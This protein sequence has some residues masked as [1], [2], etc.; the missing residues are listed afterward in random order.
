M[1]YKIN[2][3]FAYTNEMKPATFAISVFN[4]APAEATILLNSQVPYTPIYSG[5][6]DCIKNLWTIGTAPLRYKKMKK[7]LLVYAEE[8]IP[9]EYNNILRYGYHEPIC[10]A[11]KVSDENGTSIPDQWL[12]TPTELAKYLIHKK[13]NIWL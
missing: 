10:I 12:T 2:R 5:E 7:T 9:E 4:T 11:M 6:K 1:Q 13:N 8:H 3:T